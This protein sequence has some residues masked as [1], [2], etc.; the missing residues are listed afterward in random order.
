MMNYW[1]VEQPQFAL[2]KGP[3]WLAIDAASGR[4]SGAPDRVGQFEVVVAVTLQREERTLDPAQLQW[5]VEKVVDSRPRAVGAA[6][7]AFV[8]EVKP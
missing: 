7:Q 2:E 5:G 6:Q 4:L 8:I 1:D 3:S